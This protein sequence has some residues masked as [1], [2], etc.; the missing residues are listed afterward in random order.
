LVALASLDSSLPSSMLWIDTIDG[1]HSL[2]PLTRYTD[3]IG[4]LLSVFTWSRRLR[5]GA[6]FAVGSWRCRRSTHR[7]GC[8][9]HLPTRQDNRRRPQDNT[10]NKAP[11][12]CP[13]KGIHR[14]DKKMH[15]GKCP[16]L[17]SQSA[18]LS[19]TSH[20]TSITSRPK[21]QAPHA[22]RPTPRQG[23]AA[24]CRQ[25]HHQGPH[26]NPP[27]SCP[28]ARPAALVRSVPP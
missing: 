2:R 12:P 18:S 25:T 15:N 8:S 13:I 11:L 10:Q 16:H 4:F 7:D 19:V 1:I 21:R 5:C 22:H 27:C 3:P 26:Q 14:Q 9:S 20:I 23:Q 24:S 6:S 28:A 17:L